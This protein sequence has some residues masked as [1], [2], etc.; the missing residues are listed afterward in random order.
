MSEFIVTSIKPGETLSK[1]AA[2]HGVRVEDL[3]R[4]NNIADPDVILVGQEIIVYLDT[5]DT[6]LVQ[7]FLSATPLSAEQKPVPNAI[8]FADPSSA[9]VFI[10]LALG[11]VLLIVLRWTRRT[12]P[13]VS[14]PFSADLPRPSADSRARVND[15]ERHV[16]A[17]LRRRYRDWLLLDD[18]MLPSGQGTT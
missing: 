12:V 2:Q 15:G 18:I 4:W 14:R 5:P 13:S 16:S 7:P 3:Q 6:A 9:A 8:S 17:V 11:L 1:I 10:V